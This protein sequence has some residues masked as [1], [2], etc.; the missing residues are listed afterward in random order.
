MCAG[1]SA[2]IGAPIAEA[3]GTPSPRCCLLSPISTPPYLPLYILH[4]NDSGAL[5]DEA[6]DY[7]GA[8]YLAGI[9]IA[10]SGVICFPL[11]AINRWEKRREEARCY[12]MNGDYEMPK[13]NCDVQPRVMT[14][15]RPCLKLTTVDNK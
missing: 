1:L 2:F 15:I 5:S 7:K 3:K 8:F 13:R 12:K 9:T 10:F 11:R 6:G 14:F 4:F